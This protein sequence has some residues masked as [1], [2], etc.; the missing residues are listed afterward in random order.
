MLGG[1]NAVVVVVLCVAFGCLPDWRRGHQNIDLSW[2]AA[3]P[4]PLAMPEVELGEALWQA[5]EDGETDRAKELIAAKANIE[6]RQPVCMHTDAQNGHISCMFSQWSPACS[7]RPSRSRTLACAQARAA[8]P[9][10]P[11]GL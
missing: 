5:C 11:S 6:W 8:G 4:P 2:T 10:Q 3:A 7:C 1:A 9:P